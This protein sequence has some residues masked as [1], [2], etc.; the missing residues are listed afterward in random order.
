MCRFSCPTAVASGNDAVTPCNK[1]SLLYKEAKW[2]GKSSDGGP[3]W[4]VYDCT[5]CG[6]CTEYCAYEMPVAARLFE[7]RATREFHWDRAKLAAAALTE[8]QD[9]VGDLADEL[10][11]AD[12]ARERLEAFRASGSGV[13][14][15]P[16][17]AWFARSRGV[18]AKLRWEDALGAE[19]SAVARERLSGRRWL[20]HESVWLSRR[21]GASEAVAAWAARSGHAISLELPFHNGRDC[22]DCGGE[23]AY[24]RLFPG[25]AAAM[26]RAFW[27]RDQHRA[28]GILAMSRR[29]AEHLRASL[30]PGVPVEALAELA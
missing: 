16:R 28:D 6:R 10:G 26:A 23:G 7:A 24:S 20:L 12:A 27:E 14:E 8:L 22:I 11:D 21:L 19:L 29:C 25:Q 2:P 3:L 17:S 13:V 5:G 4:P 1:M 15:E 9:A 30:G 18:S